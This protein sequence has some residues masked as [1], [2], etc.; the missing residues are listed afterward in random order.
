MNTDRMSGVSPR[1]YPPVI[2]ADGAY[3]TA[4][5]RIP[6]LPSETGALET[7][8]YGPDRDACV[9]EAVRADRVWSLYPARQCDDERARQR[10]RYLASGGEEGAA[11]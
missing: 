1:W 8:V 3:W 10:I 11:Q 4:R 5:L 2:D 9:R 6:L 7:E